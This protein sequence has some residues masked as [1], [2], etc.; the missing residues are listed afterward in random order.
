MQESHQTLRVLLH[1]SL[2][3][4]H[5]LGHYGD[6]TSVGWGITCLYLLCA[7][8]LLVVM[9]KV[10]IAERKE[11]LVWCGIFVIVCLLT[12][13]KQLDLQMLVTDIAR[14]ITK[15]YGVYDN[16]K[17]FQLMAIVIFGISFLS[18]GG[19]FLYLLRKS[20]GSILLGLIGIIVLFMFLMLRLLSHHYLES[21]FMKRQWLLTRYDIMEIS[22]IL[23]I[24]GS[25]CWLYM[26]SPEKNSVHR[27]MRR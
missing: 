12:M 10:L 26:V 15:E 19:F 1:R 23:L 18:I 13:N 9:K 8:V 20:H 22:G 3:D 21:F 7:I 16:R 4:G 5:W 6:F 17:P 11:R 2:Q 27:L 24:L 14:T 25:A